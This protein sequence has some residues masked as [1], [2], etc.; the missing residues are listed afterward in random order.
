MKKFIKKASALK[1]NETGPNPAQFKVDKKLIQRG[2]RIKKRPVRYD[3]QDT[4][5]E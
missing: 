5:T 2:D 4:A 3:P 1:M